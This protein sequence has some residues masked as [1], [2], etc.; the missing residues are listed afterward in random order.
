MIKMK[1]QCRGCNKMVDNLNYDL[2]CIDCFEGIKPKKIIM[3]YSVKGL[4]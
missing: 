3:D 2:V 1:G 4:D